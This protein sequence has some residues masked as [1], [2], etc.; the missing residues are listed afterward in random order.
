MQFFYVADYLSTDVFLQDR[1]ENA[2]ERDRSIV[3]GIM[4]F[5]CLRN[6]YNMRQFPGFE[7]L[8]QSDRLIKYLSDRR[9]KR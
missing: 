2:K 4:L 8:A 7:Y 5:R 3:I 6:R 9:G 1:T